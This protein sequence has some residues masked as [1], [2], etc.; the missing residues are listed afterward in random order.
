[1]ELGLGGDVRWAPA[2]SS[3]FVDGRLTRFTTP[4][5]FARFPAVGAIDKLRLAATIRYAGRMSDAQ[6]LAVR[7]QPIETWLRERSGD[8]AF[9]RLWRPLLQAK[10]GERYDR[11]SASFIVAT[12]RRLYAGEAGGRARGHGYV[13]G[14]YARILERCVSQLADERVTVECGLGVERIE[15]VPGAGV[16]VVSGGIRRVY[17]AAVLT[18]PPPVAVGLVPSLPERERD[19]WMRV[20]YRG[21][22]CLSLLLDRALGD[23]YL[24]YIADE[25]IPFTAIVETSN[26]VDPADLGGNHLVY[27]P[28]YVLHDDEYHVLDDENVGLRFTAALPL[29][30]RNFDPRSVLA[31]RLSRV[32]DVYAPPTIDD[33][34][35]LPFTTGLDGVFLA[36]SAQIVDGTLNVNQTLELAD[37]AA[38]TVCE[39]TAPSMV[40]GA[41]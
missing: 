15:P 8:V 16:A 18:V 19:A 26:I 5:D 10:L 1:D 4:L 39:R 36:S 6:L 35:P 28:K 38:T 12:M 24:T 34:Q 31:M 14:G 3:F 25:R 32:K 17:D 33:V 40:R 41:A 2:S 20:H 7:E 11:V 9:E 37:R 23:S 30:H 29:I 22:L 27:L 13:R 21:V